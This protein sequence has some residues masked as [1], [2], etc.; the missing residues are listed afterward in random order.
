MKL[1]IKEVSKD[2]AASYQLSMYSSYIYRRGSTPP[3]AE[4]A[5]DDGGV[6]GMMT[7]HCFIHTYA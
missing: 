3:Y 1:G 2:G 7:Q 4:E 5:V 6:L